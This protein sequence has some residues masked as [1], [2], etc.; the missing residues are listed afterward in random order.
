MVRFK[1]NSTIKLGGIVAIKHLPTKEVH[2]GVKGGS[3]RCGADTTKHPD[4]WVVSLEKV[5]CDKSGCKG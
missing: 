2:I 1:F 4:Y 3:T 5:T